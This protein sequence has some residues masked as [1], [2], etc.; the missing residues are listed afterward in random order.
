M[1]N[2]LQL[3]PSFVM[4]GMYGLEGIACSSSHS[5]SGIGAP[6]HIT[7]NHSGVS[8]LS[9]LGSNLER[10]DAISERRGKNSSFFFDDCRSQEMIAAAKR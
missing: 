4:S 7:I 6:N 9:S 8:S 1:M 10:D 3:L 2:R 5:L